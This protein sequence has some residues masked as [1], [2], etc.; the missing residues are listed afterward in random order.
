MDVIH[1]PRDVCVLEEKTH[2]SHAVCIEPRTMKWNDGSAHL[3][4]VVTKSITEVKLDEKVFEVVGLAT[5]K[6]DEVRKSAEVAPGI[7]DMI[8]S[9]L[10]RI[11]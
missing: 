11:C 2:F 7:A 1:M 8:G 4:P 6:L 10:D 5:P 9:N 3:L